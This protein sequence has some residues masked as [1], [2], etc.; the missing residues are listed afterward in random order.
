MYLFK[1]ILT[2]GVAYESLPY[3]TR[4]WL[5]GQLG[6]YIERTYQHGVEQFIDLL[7]FHYGRSPNMGKQREYLRRAGESAQAAYANTAAIDYY[8]RLLPL[9]DADQQGPVSLRL[10]Q[11]LEVVGEFDEAA[12]CYQRAL[13]L[14]QQGNDT[15]AEIECRRLIG[16]L[17]R[18]QG[19]FNEAL[20]WLREAQS[21]YARLGDSAGAV[22]AL[23]DIGE[24][25]RLQGSYAEARIA[26]DES[27]ALSAGEQPNRLLQAARAN[28]L[29]GAGTLANQQGQGEVARALYEESLDIRRQLA[30]KP[31]IAVML[32]NLGVEALYRED[33]GASYARFAESLAV[34]REIGDLWA[35]GQLLNNTGMAARGRSDFGEARSL[36]EQSVHVRRRIGDRWGV[37][38]ALNSLT[39]LL[40]H[41]G[42]PGS[43]R[44]LLVESL[45][46]NREIGDRTA[47]AYCLED[48]AGLAAAEGH[49]ATALRLAGAAAALREAIGSPLPSG[50]QGALDQLLN[51][52]RAVLSHDEAETALAAGHAL[53]LE[54]AVELAL[55][56]K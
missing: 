14:A 12:L 29:K 50:E 21:G 46:L 51:P 28:A 53:G 56:P 18:K 17:L 7:A 45:N 2:H 19:A 24:V 32:N 6:D 30:D 49:A 9:L 25:H 52:A 43:V 27:L 23:A 8:R 48:F 4:A 38:N 42:E 33:Y 37:A 22:Q 35:T 15:L 3:E 36:L 44:P 20:T 31:G 40:L 16:W 34:F 5:H 11:V 13:E 47:I 39:N 1:H 10:G 55:Q 26:Y 54:A 41:I